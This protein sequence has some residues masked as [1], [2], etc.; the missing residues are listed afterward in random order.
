MNKKILPGVTLYVL[1][2]GFG[3]AGK[4]LADFRAQ[5]MP[6]NPNG[7]PTEIHADAQN[8]LWIS[9]FLA[10]EIWKVNAAGDGFT[11]YSLGNSSFPTDAHA[12]GQG[13]VW[14][15][16]GTNLGR[17]NLGDNTTQVWDVSVSTSLSGL[18]IDSLGMIWM[19]DSG[20][21][22]IYRFD[23]AHTETCTYTLPAASAEVFYPLVVGSQLWLADSFN[24]Q[25]LNLN[26]S[27]TPEWTTWQL[28]VNSTPYFL[29]QDSSGDIWF[30]DNGLAQLGRLSPSSN[31]L[32]LF[33]LPAGSLPA[34]LAASAGKIWY[35]EQ[36]LA[37]IGSLDPSQNLAIPA[38][39]TPSITSASS[40][41]ITL[42]PP[43]SGSASTS[44]GVPSWANSNYPTVAQGNGWRIN[45][46]PSSSN[47][48][49]IALT[50]NGFVVD[51]GRKV[52]IRYNPNQSTIFLPIIVR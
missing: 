51:T 11:T 36:S 26:L 4:A 28:P 13:G 32:T 7:S 8:N 6:L 49:G 23:P 42:N 2:F 3:L 17:L 25:L 16:S 1:L 10:G 5:E 27:G 31:E 41:C 19:S 50:T 22:H 18:G 34:M 21:G 47:P 40:S 48:N 38:V 14:W 46:L 45:Q 24:G 44:S 33:P 37:S 12:D 9:E 52:L 30:T 15:V 43:T 35:T 39:V 20:I 29:T